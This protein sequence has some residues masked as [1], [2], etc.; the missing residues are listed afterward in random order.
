M[1]SIVPLKN[2]QSSFPPTIHRH[3][4][5]VPAYLRDCER[6][7]GRIASIA[8]HAIF[9]IFLI[10][11]FVVEP[12]VTDGVSMRP[13]IRDNTFFLVEK[14]SSLFL[15]PKR[16]DI[17]Q[18][19]DPDDRSQLIIKRIVGLPGETVIFDQ[20]KVF[21]QKK[22]GER[23]PLDER[24]LSPNSINTIPHGGKL[25]TTVPEDSY[26]ILGDNRTNSRDSRF[27]GPVHRRLITGKIYPIALH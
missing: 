15:S 24:Y 1:P 20:N 16:Y 14:M 10:R 5:R 18:S 27:F 26:F 4:V 19:L 22:K 23:Q 21:I 11:F 9:F 25:A 3:V 6:Y 8:A 2:S 7:I 17:V 13:T 12:G